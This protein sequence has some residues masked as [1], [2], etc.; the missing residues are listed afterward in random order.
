[1]ASDVK[2]RLL[3]TGTIL[4]DANR[5]C[6]S[7]LVE[8]RK[9]KILIDAGPG[10]LYRIKQIGLAPEDIH[11]IFLTHF[12]PDHVCDL[13]PILFALKNPYS[14]SKKLSL[15]IWGPRGFNNFMHNLEL[16]YG[17][18]IH[19]FNEQIQFNELKRQ[20]IDFPGFRVI[21]EKVV[22]KYES[23]GYRF[24]I[25]NQVIAISGDSGYCPE[26]IRLSRNADLAILECS[27]PDELAVE[28]HLSPSLAARIAQEAKAKQLVLT[29][30]Y[31]GTIESDLV[32]VAQKYFNGPIH[33]A[34]DLM[35]FAIPGDST[36]NKTPE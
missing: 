22:H 12:H 6:S 35:E 30:F 25:G 9:E 17:K 14:G 10:T 13:V 23:V 5:Y 29:H 31:P 16:A 26:L 20:L 28:G 32:E 21:W 4:A 18:W 19:S 2:V 27:F 24:E 15:R 1:M 3:G 7:V 11:F 8:T 33:L 36:T 34:E